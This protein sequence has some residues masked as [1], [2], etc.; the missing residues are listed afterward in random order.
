MA[1]PPANLV[2]NASL[3]PVAIKVIVNDMVKDMA[4]VIKM[5][6][7]RVEYFLLIFKVLPSEEKLHFQ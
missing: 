5:A 6:S 7:N 2:G 3:K 4:R 1:N